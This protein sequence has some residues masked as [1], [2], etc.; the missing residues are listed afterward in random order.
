MSEL[1]YPPATAV[2]G[3]LEQHFAQQDGVPAPDA[4]A[5]AAVI[6]AAFWAS[7]RREEGYAARLSL[8]LLAPEHV[9]AP[10]RFERPLPLSPEAR[11]Q[12]LTAPAGTGFFGTNGSAVQRATDRC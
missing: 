9:G 2:A 7:L 12:H 11:H 8:A 4:G 6:D 10:L 5:I 1:A 3:R